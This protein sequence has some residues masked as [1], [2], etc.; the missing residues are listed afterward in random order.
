LEREIP[1]IFP[2]KWA[3]KKRIFDELWRREKDLERKTA[4]LEIVT[5][6]GPAGAGKSTVSRLLA[7]R[8]GYFYLDTGAMYRAVALRA[9]K[10][11]I[12]PEDDRGLERLCQGIEIDF[13]DGLDGQRLICQREDVTEAI[14]DP[15]IGRL[16]SAVSMR[17]PVREA[18][19]A[20]QRKMG[21]RGRMVAEGRDTGTVVFP[22]AKHKFFLNADPLERS[23]RRYRELKAKGLDVGLE[24]VDREVRERDAQDSSRELAPLRPAEDARL[25]DSTGL[26]PEE[27]VDEIVAAMGKS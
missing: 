3:K 25:V 26:T 11:G 7:R 21:S 24:A 15:E 8:L 13:R 6:D 12:G 14:R 19:A 18:M 2:R 9:R 22:R 27:V 16:A 10:E 23:R 20:L 4:S 5:I 17:R 1:L